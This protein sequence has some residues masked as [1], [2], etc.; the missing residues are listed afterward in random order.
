MGKLRAKWDTALSGG[1]VC[2]CVAQART[3]GARRENP[4]S[5]TKVKWS[6]EPLENAC[7]VGSADRG[8]CPNVNCS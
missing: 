6:Y 4:C 7:K 2:Y 8:N 1:S 5:L 3:R